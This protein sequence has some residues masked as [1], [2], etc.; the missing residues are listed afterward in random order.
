MS[1]LPD[2]DIARNAIQLRDIAM[3]ILMLSGRIVMNVNTKIRY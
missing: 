3:P 2:I 1:R